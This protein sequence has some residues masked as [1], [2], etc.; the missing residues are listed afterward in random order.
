MVY[1]PAGVPPVGGL[2]LLLLPQAA[3]RRIKPASRPSSIP[4]S[5]RRRFNPAPA[6]RP[7]KLNPPTGSQVA[8]NG[9]R[10]RR[11][12]VLTGRAVVLIFSVVVTGL[13][14]GIV[15]ELE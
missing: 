11:L 10:G 3:C 15:T 5:Q 14:P 1:V 8:Y 4:A 9:P 13:L 7:S 6:P 12:P 2:L